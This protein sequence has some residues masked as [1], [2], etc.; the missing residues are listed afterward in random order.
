MFQCSRYFSYEDTN[1]ISHAP[2]QNTLGVTLK[3][4]SNTSS[5]N[6]SKTDTVYKS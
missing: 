2:V 6:T 5:M 4:I 1:L 3:W